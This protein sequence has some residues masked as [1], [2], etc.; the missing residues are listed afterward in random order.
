MLL[1]VQRERVTTGADAALAAMFSTPALTANAEESTK[2]VA[3]RSTADLP[4]STPPP[5]TVSVVRVP[6]PVPVDLGKSALPLKPLPQITPAPAAPIARRS[7]AAES[8]R[9][10]RAT[11]R[12]PQSAKSTR[13]KRTPDQ[14]LDEARAATAGWPDAKVTA[15]GIRRALHTSPANA[16]TLRD[17]ILAERAATA[18]EAVA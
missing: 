11:G 10:R 17:T 12:V 2:T 6:D 13:P 18:G 14:L 3:K 7:V 15:E 5:V 8:T 1:D 4:E 9:P 16:R